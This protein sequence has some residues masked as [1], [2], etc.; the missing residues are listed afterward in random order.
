MI[1]KRCF[2]KDLLQQA[3]TFLESNMIDDY[4][5]KQ[6]IIFEKTKMD[7]FFEDHSNEIKNNVRGLQY[8]GFK[9]DYK[10]D[11]DKEKEQISFDMIIWFTNYTSDCDD[12]KDTWKS[13]MKKPNDEKFSD[14][15]LEFIDEKKEINFIKTVV[16]ENKHNLLGKLIRLHMALK[17][18]RNTFNHANDQ[19]PGL[20]VIKKA[21]K[22]Y[23]DTYEEILE[24]IQKN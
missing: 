14:T 13:Y 1:V 2:E 17:S 23:I 10:A 24:S 12:K 20:K 18:C 4:L 22:K 19:R 16:S 15:F 21:F 9:K 6:I 7:K 8:G 11:R 5:E 3:L